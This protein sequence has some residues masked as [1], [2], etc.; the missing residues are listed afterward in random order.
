MLKHIFFGAE[1]CWHSD[2][3]W[4]L[5]NSCRLY[6]IAE[7]KISMRRRIFQRF[8]VVSGIFAVV[9]SVDTESVS[10]TVT[11]KSACTK[12]LIVSFTINYFRFA[13]L[14]ILMI[15]KLMYTLIG[16]FVYY[17]SRR[18][19][20]TSNFLRSRTYSWSRTKLTASMEGCLYPRL[21]ELPSASFLHF[22]M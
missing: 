19:D 6:V 12:I 8:S 13:S 4:H 21:V 18:V 10:H 20:S 22:H 1:L 15:D 14:S 11:L 16:T 3:K 7:E 5:N 9:F 17:T 2:F